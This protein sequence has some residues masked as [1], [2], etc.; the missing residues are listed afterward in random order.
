M[1]LLR[2]VFELIEQFL[3][4][5]GAKRREDY[6]YK[7]GFTWQM[8]GSDEGSFASYAFGVAQIGEHVQGVLRGDLTDAELFDD[9]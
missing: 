1:L 4:H 5:R 9:L 3:V 6:S 8:P 2:E 7:E